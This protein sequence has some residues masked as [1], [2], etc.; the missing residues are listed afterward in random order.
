MT[1]LHWAL[2]TDSCDV[3][4]LLINRGADVNYPTDV[5]DTPLILSI[6]DCPEVTALLIEKGATVEPVGQRGMNALHLAAEKSKPATI[7]LLLNAGA[8][9]SV[10]DEKGR[11][12]LDIAT[13]EENQAAIPLLQLE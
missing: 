12:P 3:A 10:T 13:E 5:N 7:R 2:I 1:A 9:R 8:D 11:T 4:T 6:P